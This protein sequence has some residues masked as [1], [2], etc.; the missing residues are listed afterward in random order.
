[1][2]D[3]VDIPF[4]VKLVSQQT[5]GL[6]LCTPCERATLKKAVPEALLRVRNCFSA[7]GNKYYSK[8]KVPI[9]NP[10]H[11]GQYTIFLYFLSRDVFEK[12]GE[13]QLADKLYY[14][15]KVLNGCDLF[16][17]VKL[18]PVFFNEHPVGSVIGR[19]TFSN[20]FVFQ[21]NCTV[22]GNKG[23]YPILGE[24]VWLFANSVVIGASHIGNNVFV[25]AGTYIKD[26]VVPDNSIVFGRSPHLTIKQKPP[27]Y[28]TSKSPFHV[29]HGGG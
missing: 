21:Q 29:H 22:G 1:M 25:S 14:L 28:F 19:G 6:F 27:E 5:K 23:A 26:A 15:N 7:I 4:L 2:S 3:F 17:E 12:Y 20:Y 10:F 13:V 9:F 8:E 18:P 11:S 24:Y 16:Y